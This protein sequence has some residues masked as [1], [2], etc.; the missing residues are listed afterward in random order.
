[1]ALN[2]WGPAITTTNK[3]QW[4]STEQA[5]ASGCL[6]PEANVKYQWYCCVMKQMTNMSASRKVN[7]DFREM[8]CG[9]LSEGFMVIAANIIIP[10][11]QE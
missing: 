9:E 4:H 2:E 10:H 5:C 1:M 6:V 3:R 7:N 11:G 8:F